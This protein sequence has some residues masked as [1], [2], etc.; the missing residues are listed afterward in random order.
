[1]SSG[2]SSEPVRQHNSVSA[3]VSKNVAELLGV[4]AKKH[5]GK[6]RKGLENN[7]A[8][9]FSLDTITYWKP[10]ISMIT[11]MAFLESCHQGSHEQS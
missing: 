10:K 7:P 1:M 2:L 6:K 3:T 11:M 8:F 5:V 4:D 9:P